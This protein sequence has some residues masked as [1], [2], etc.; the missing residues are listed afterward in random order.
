MQ[1][2]ADMLSWKNCLLTVLR[3]AVIRLSISLFVCQLVVES[4]FVLLQFVLSVYR[5]S[6]EQLRLLD[7][8]R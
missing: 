5:C 2:C 8:M 6:Q 1:S 7:A 4:R 3:V